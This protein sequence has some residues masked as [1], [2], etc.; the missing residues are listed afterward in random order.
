MIIEQ[1]YDEGLAH[2]S[3]A[4]VSQNEVAVIDPA[5]NPQPYYDFA[6]T[7]GARI[8]AVVETHPHA[9]F[10]SAHLEMH[11]HTGA[12][13]YASKLLDAA[14]PHRTFDNG[15]TIMIGNIS[16]KA[17]NTPG[18]SPDSI[19][20]LAEDEEG[21]LAAIFTGDT[22]LV[23]D[24][25]RPDLRETAGNLKAKKEELA[26]AMY[27]TTR[28]VLMKLPPDTLVYPAHGPGSLCA[29]NMGPDLHSTIG[30]ELHT[31]PLLASMSEQDFVDL[32]IGNQSFIPGYFAQTVELNKYGAAA[33]R[34][35]IAAVKRLPKGALL[36]EAVLIVDTRPAGE[37]KAAHLVKAINIPDGARFETWLGTIVMPGEE[38]YMVASDAS[39]VEKMIARAA[40]IG[41]EAQI[42]GAMAEPGGIKT[43][44]PLFD[45]GAFEQNQ[46]SYTIVDIRNEDEI[47]E[48]MIFENTIHIPL[49]QLRNRAKGL[50][51]D[52]PIVVH[53]AGGYRSA[54]GSSLVEQQIEGAA[55]LDMG[56]N[57]SRY[58]ESR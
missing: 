45:A 35:S 58:A 3:Y 1:F 51:V 10:V 43:A 22:L 4:V 41:Y 23:G 48:G 17:M 36:D 28:N 7:H 33:Y 12:I 8:V 5:R 18:H 2:S 16:L 52:K 39:A 37:F 42:R 15:D 26:K 50:P 31:N 21:N 19:S 11:R 6:V 54:I 38:F 57:I 53:C 56:S 49:P 14:Y 47:A 29:K 44:S 13:V 9:D 25:G 20:I 46:E 40:K 30:K 32:L 27:K 55:V 24:V 34:E